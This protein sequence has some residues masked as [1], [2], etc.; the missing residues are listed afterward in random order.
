MNCTE[1]S[2]LSRLN[3]LE[4][5]FSFLSHL[6]GISVSILAIRNPKPGDLSLQSEPYEEI[7]KAIIRTSE[8]RN[9]TEGNEAEKSGISKERKINKCGI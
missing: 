2:R 9:K 4:A 8:F 7:A 1:R 3:T 5:S 6:S